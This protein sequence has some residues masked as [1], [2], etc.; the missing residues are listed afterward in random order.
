MNPP[1]PSLKHKGGC[2]DNIILD[3][4]VIFIIYCIY[5]QIFS[6][7]APLP[8]FF[9]GRGWGMGSGIQGKGMGDGFR[10]TSRGKD[11]GENI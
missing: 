10:Y 1:R 3:I 4:T 5:I 11:R 8:L 6:G 9:K 2:H 7:M